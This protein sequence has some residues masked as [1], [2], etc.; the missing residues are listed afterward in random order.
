MRLQR[1]DKVLM[2][3]LDCLKVVRGADL[4]RKKREL[5]LYRTSTYIK[6]YTSILLRDTV[7]YSSP[8]LDMLVIEVTGKE[9]VCYRLEIE[10][11]NLLPIFQLALVVIIPTEVSLEHHATSKD[12]TSI[13]LKDRKSSSLTC[14]CRNRGVEYSILDLKLKK[15][16]A[17][18][19]T[20]FS[21]HHIH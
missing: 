20:G 10:K 17:N 14:L 7:L 15:S 12:T 8:S 16:L 4:V 3:M 21:C 1:G 9:I 5:C 11:K 13:S 6:G 19:L 2:G 18:I